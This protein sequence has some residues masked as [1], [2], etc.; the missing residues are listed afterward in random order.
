LIWALFN[1]GYIVYLSFAV[2]AVVSKGFTPMDAAISVSLAS[3]VMIFSGIVCGQ[4]ADRAGRPDLILYVCMAVAAAAVLGITHTEW[5]VSSALAFGLIGAA[6]AGVIMALTGESMA[7]ERRAFGMGVFFSVYFVVI[8][9]VP[10]LAGWLYDLS[11]EPAYAM[12]LAA[13]LFLATAATNAGFR[14]VQRAGSR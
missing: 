7:P 3:W 9:P 13:A 14:M 10:T 2:Q 1:A 6:P 11:N 4:L 12:Y 8:A 5:V